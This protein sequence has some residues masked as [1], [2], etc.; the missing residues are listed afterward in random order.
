MSENPECKIHLWLAGHTHSF[1]R[2][3][4]RSGQYRRI[5]ANKTCGGYKM[6]PVARYPYTIL[7]GEYGRKNNPFSG[8]I[9]D[10][11]PGVLE[12]STILPDGTVLDHFK[13]KAD[14][15]VEN[16]SSLPE[17]KVF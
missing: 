6:R 3:T 2:T 15:S 5:S 8:I 17:I 13:I 9:V 4:P 14:S 1:L 10:V 7:T 16:I 11:A 12:V